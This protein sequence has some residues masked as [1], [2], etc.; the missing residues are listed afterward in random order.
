MTAPLEV[1]TAKAEIDKGSE[2]KGAKKGGMH[3]AVLYDDGARDTGGSHMTH[4]TAAAAG[5]NGGKPDFAYYQDKIQGAFPDPGTPCL[6][7]LCRIQPPYSNTCATDH[8][9]LLRNNAVPYDQR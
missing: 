6:V 9:W 2:H 4:S 3:M 7:F 1:D 5:Y 8:R